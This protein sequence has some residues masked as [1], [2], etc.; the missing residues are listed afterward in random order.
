MEV[1]DGLSAVGAVVDDD[2]EAVFEVELAGEFCG[3][4]EEVAEG[5][6]VFGGGVAD[7]RNGFA[8]DDQEVCGRLRVD[9]AERYAEVVLVFELAGDVPVHDFLEE[10]LVHGLGIVEGVG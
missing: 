5:G 10:G 7:A 3:G 1:G 2:A 9:V 8:G 4:E 6:L